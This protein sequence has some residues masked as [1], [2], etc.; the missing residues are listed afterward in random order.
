MLGSRLNARHS[1][2]KKQQQ[3]KKNSL[4]DTEVQQVNLPNNYKFWCHDKEKKNP[5]HTGSA[6]EE[7][8]RHVEVRKAFLG[9]CVYP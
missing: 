5:N 3:T 4:G 6:R 8:N 9:M 2:I 1:A 7:H